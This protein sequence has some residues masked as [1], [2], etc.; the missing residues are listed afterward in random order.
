MKKI[1]EIESKNKDFYI[2][3]FS[4]NIDVAIKEIKINK[5]NF[6]FISTEIIELAR[7]RYPKLLNFFGILIDNE[8]IKNDNEI[9]CSMVFELMKYNLQSYILKE[10]KEEKKNFKSKIRIIKEISELIYYLHQNNLIHGDLRTTKILLDN[11]VC[12]KIY[13]NFSHNKRQ[14]STYS[15]PEIILNEDFRL[16][17]DIWSFGCLIYFILFENDL[18]TDLEDVKIGLNKVNFEKKV[19]KDKNKIPDELINLIEK[20]LSYNLENRPNAFD[21]L[22]NMKKIFLEVS[23]D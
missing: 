6:E 17:N 14:I 3:L 10:I 16:E 12:V 21:C 4:E 23:C 22:T 9:T 1:T 5:E 18:F 13:L 2:G 11:N 15:S 8:K 19:E 7:F 20:C